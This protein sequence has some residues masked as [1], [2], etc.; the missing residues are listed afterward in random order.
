MSCVDEKKDIAVDN[1]EKD[2]LPVRKNPKIKTIIAV[3]LLCAIILLNLFAAIIGD[4]RLWYLDLTRGKYKSQEAAF[5][6]LSD[7]CRSLILSDAI[8]M[9]K[10]VNAERKQNGEDT[11]RVKVVFCTDKDYIEEDDM[12]RYVSFTARALAKEFPDEI[13]VEYINTVKNPSAVQKYKTTSAASIYPSDVIVEFGSEYLVQSINSFYYT[14]EAATEPWAYNGEKRLSAMI[15]ALTRAESPICCITTNHGETLF[16]ANGNVK[17][18]YSTF[19]NVIEGAGYIVQF[20]DLEKEDIPENCRMMITFNPT[21]DFRAFG[22]LGE[23]GVSE[24]EKLDKY[25]DAANAFFYVCD[26][27]TPVLD[28]LEEYLEEWGVTVTRVADNADSFDSYFVKDAI[29]C[30]DSGEGDMIVGDYA[31]EGLG[32]LMTEDMRRAAYPAKVVF[33]NSTSISPAPNYYKI[34]VAAD[35]ESGTEAFNYYHY[36][37]NGVS[38]SMLDVF[39]THE[40]AYAKVADEQYEIATEHNRFKLMTVTQE[41]RQVQEDNFTTINRASYVISLASTDF[42]KNELLESKAYGNTDVITSVLRT[43][44]NEVVPTDIDLKAFYNY[45]VTDSFAYRA[46]KPD[47]WSVWL[48]ATPAALALIVGVVVNIRRRYK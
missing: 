15:L 1:F 16:D 31:T 10:A 37:K 30:I 22:D 44:G 29:N 23:G 2:A 47:V 28:N 7:E 26:R 41:S 48:M 38:R 20:L 34:F 8:P 33:G 45:N 18:E 46:V 25:L 6:T 9:V 11:I 39:T 5:Y 19:I 32:A 12:M 27:G 4:G 42:L 43:T 24:I 14:D 3:I 17:A 36:Y 40:T 35:A 21:I 13:E